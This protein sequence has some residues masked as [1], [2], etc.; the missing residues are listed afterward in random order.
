MGARYLKAEEKVI[1][2]RYPTA[3]RAEVLMLIPNRTW[4][5][6]GVHARA[7]GI[8]RTTQTR[9][10]SIREGRKVLRDSWS[11]ADNMLLDRLYPTETRAD[12]IAAFPNRSYIAI[13]LHA[14]RRHLQRTRYATGRQITIG[15]RNAKENDN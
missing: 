14:Q 5:Q 4:A 10:N 13:Q 7:M 1:V 9:G 2:E 11:D 3:P 12:L 8:H 15:R 6:I